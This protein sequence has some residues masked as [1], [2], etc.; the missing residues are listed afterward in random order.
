MRILF[1]WFS[2]TWRW[3]GDVTSTGPWPCHSKSMGLSVP[4]VF[5]LQKLEKSCLAIVDTTPVLRISLKRQDKS[6]QIDLILSV[7]IQD[8]TCL[9]RSYDCVGKIEAPEYELIP[10]S[11]S[12]CCNA[13]CRVDTVQLSKVL[14]AKAAL[15]LGQE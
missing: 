14:Y 8:I 2:I 4:L 10:Q 11:S 7:L 3:K 13:N 15:D 1:F 6:K 9:L 5:I 12:K